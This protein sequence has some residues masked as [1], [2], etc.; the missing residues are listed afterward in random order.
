MPDMRI[1]SLDEVCSA[2]ENAVGYRLDPSQRNVLE[3]AYKRALHGLQ[4]GCISGALLVLEC[5]FG[6]T[7]I[8]LCIIVMTGMKTLWVTKGGKTGILAKLKA[9]VQ[10]VLAHSWPS[11]PSNY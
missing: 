6:K 8:A 4:H 9:E 1:L 3:Y 5:G 11:K 7:I 2:V 10:D